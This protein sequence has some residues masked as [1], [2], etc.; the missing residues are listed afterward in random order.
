MLRKEFHIFG[1]C[2]FCFVSLQNSSYE[3][4]W[5]IG[6]HCNQKVVAS[7]LIPTPPSTAG[8][9]QGNCS[10]LHHAVMDNSFSRCPGHF[11]FFWRVLCLPP[12][13]AWIPMYFYQCQYPCTLSEFVLDLHVFSFCWCSL[14]YFFSSFGLWHYLCMYQG[15]LVYTF[16]PYLWLNTQIHRSK[17]SPNLSTSLGERPEKL[18]IY[19]LM[20]F[21][22]F[23]PLGK[24]RTYRPHVNI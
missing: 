22:W 10:T 9:C 20:N 12:P 1:K 15:C 13:Q 21:A 23:L 8:L 11:S 19:H 6:T 5:Y 2:Q 3:R 18:V 4:L 24:F 14:A 7:G 16:N 17:C